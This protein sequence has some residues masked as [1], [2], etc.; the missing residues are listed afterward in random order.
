MKI[1]VWFFVLVVGALSVMGGASPAGSRLG[2]E[3]S[4]LLAD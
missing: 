1:L 2:P 4:V 3:A